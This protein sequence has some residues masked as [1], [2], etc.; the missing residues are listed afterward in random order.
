MN[1][2]MNASALN[3]IPLVNSTQILTPSAQPQ[4]TSIVQLQL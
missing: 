3:Q 1:P 4:M 2:S